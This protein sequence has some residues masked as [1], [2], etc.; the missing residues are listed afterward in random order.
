MAKVEDV[1]A[2]K[3][4]DENTYVVEDEPKSEIDRLCFLLCIGSIFIAY[5]WGLTAV[6]SYVVFLLALFFLI[7]SGM[8]SVCSDSLLGLK[9]NLCSLKGTNDGKVSNC[10]HGILFRLFNNTIKNIMHLKVLLIMMYVLFVMSFGQDS[11]LMVVL[12]VLAVLCL[13]SDTE[14]DS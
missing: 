8:V 13:I 10:D 12:S 3:N 7:S 14:R 11:V 5:N 1:E 2:E 4:N 6:K 9:L